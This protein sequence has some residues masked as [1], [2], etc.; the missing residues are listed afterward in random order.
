MAL[1]KCI[2]DAGFKLDRLE[3]EVGSWLLEGSGVRLYGAARDQD[4]KDVLACVSATGLPFASVSEEVDMLALQPCITGSYE[5]L[6]AA[7]TPLQ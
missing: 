4:F 1:S 5:T 2:E 7:M 3:P 6:L